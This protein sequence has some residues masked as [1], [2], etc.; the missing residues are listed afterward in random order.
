MM[1][2]VNAARMSR[3]KEGGFTLIELMIVIAVIGILA[4]VL[5][6]KVGTV[7]T[8]AKAA[9]IDTNIRMVEAYAQSRINSWANATDNSGNLTG[10]TQAVIAADIASAFSTGG[11]N[12]QMANPFSGDIMVANLISGGTWGNDAMDI[13]SSDPGTLATVAGTIVVVPDVT[14]ISS[15]PSSGIT[16]Y[17]H[18][19]AG[20]LMNDKTIRITP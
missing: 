11:S 4:I 15:S 17:A 19:N 8:Q 13:Y 9:G 7:K 10:T 6:P 20:K 12:G 1:R 18:D 3:K 14:V 16:I 5:I 2:Q